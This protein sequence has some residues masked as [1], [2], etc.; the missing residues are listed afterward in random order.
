MNK[1]IIHQAA[2]LY[3]EK[4]FIQP[5]NSFGEPLAL[6]PGQIVPAGYRKHCKVAE[7]HFKAG[8]A[9]HKEMTTITPEEIE[10]PAVKKKSILDFLTKALRFNAL[11]R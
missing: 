1:N 6:P 8:V 2:Q 10:K 4:S 11:N 5:L 9:W 3:A 7:K